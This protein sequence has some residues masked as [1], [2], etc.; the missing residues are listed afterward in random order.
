M[1]ATEAKLLGFMKKSP[2]SVIPI[3]QRTYSW[4]EK[5]CRQLCDDIVRCGSSDK[6]AVHFIGSI[7]YVKTASLKSRTKHHCWSS[8]ASN[9]SPR[10]RS[11]WRRSPRQWV[12]PNRSTV[13]QIARSRTTTW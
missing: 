4:T 12:S 5:E 8:T 6:I 11:C 3:Y 7:V 10:S 9:A 1:E 13:F 2:Q